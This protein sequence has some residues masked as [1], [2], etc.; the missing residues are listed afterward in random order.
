MQYPLNTGTFLAA[1]KVVSSL[2]MASDSFLALSNAE[3]SS[4]DFDT[5]TCKLLFKLCG[6]DSSNTELVMLINYGACMHKS[7]HLCQ[8][9]HTTHTIPN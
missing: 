9:S 1:V 7:A 4:A 5:F 8:G 2:S 3:V 6:R